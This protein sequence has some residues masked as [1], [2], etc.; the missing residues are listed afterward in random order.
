MG[1]VLQK[2]K[3]SIKKISGG[4]IHVR[5]RKIGNPITPTIIANDNA[6]RSKKIPILCIDF[7][8]L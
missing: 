2:V 6:L 8:A 3:K 7:T 1:L 5:C 4:N